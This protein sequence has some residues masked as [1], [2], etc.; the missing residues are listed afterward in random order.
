L[1]PHKEKPKRADKPASAEDRRRTNLAFFLA[2]ALLTA[3]L[4][5]LVPSAVIAASPTEFVNPLD[6]QNPLDYV[7]HTA[8]VWGGTFVLWAGTYYLLSGYRARRVFAVVMWCLCGS[9]MLC[10]FVFGRGLGTISPELQYEGGVEFPV[11]SQIINAVSV[12]ALVVALIVV[13]RRLGKVVV[14][15]LAIA[16]ASILAL[17]V[18]NVVG[19]SQAYADY[20]SKGL[21]S[22]KLYNA[23]G[24]PRKIMQ[25]SRNKQNVMVLFLDRAISA[26][27]PYMLNERPELEGQLDGFTYYPNTL[28]FGQCTNFGVPA[29]YGGYEYTPSAMNARSSELLKD[30][31]NEAL[32]VLPTIFSHAGYQTSVVDPPYAGDYQWHA[33][34]S[35]YDDLPNTEANYI[36]S[37]YTN[38]AIARY[39]VDTD[40][41]VARRFVFYGLVRVVPEFAQGTVYDWGYYWTTKSTGSVTRRAL[42]ELATLDVLP[43]I[44]AV[45]EG[46][47]CFVQFANCLPHE[48]TL[49]QLPDY[50]PAPL[51]QNE[52]LEDK[53]RFTVGG[54]TMRT[55]T[56]YQLGHYHTNIATFLRL[57][58]FFDW[59]RENGVY[60]NTRIIMVADHGRDLWQFADFRVDHRLDIQM[61]NPL[62]MVKDFNAHGFTTSH[63]FMTNA[64]T[65]TLALAGLIKDPENP[66][67]GKAINS[68]EKYAHDQVVSISNNWNTSSNHGHVFDSSDAPWYTLSGDNVFERRNWKRFDTEPEVRK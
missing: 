65:P 47:S 40:V 36:N 32:L 22:S 66:A 23:D 17:A 1:L 5:I 16:T 27:V 42:N 33:N 7:L 61:V 51:V 25:L 26:Y 55:D 14:P 10:Y 49:L 30:K 44:T 15:A 53:S 64:D 34:V 39:G 43:E 67:T 24:T 46:P 38:Y 21:S 13:W 62:L 54:R 2:A 4:G 60:D 59:M 29:L 41:D 45:G 19:T 31:H 48:P 28:S 11:S 63:E 58:R 56:D 9:G 52:G 37:G 35:L 50:D 68:D 3:L 8:C 12:A 6:A 18:P 57:G 20:Q